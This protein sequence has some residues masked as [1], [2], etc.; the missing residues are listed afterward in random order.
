[1]YL[2]GELVLPVVSLFGIGYVAFLNEWWIPI[3]PP[4]LALVGSAIAVR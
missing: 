4:I 3:V 1:M 2:H